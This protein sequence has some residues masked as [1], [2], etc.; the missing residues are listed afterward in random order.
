MGKE[1]SGAVN[2]P[3]ASFVEQQTTEIIRERAEGVRHTR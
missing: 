1:I 2:A 3:G